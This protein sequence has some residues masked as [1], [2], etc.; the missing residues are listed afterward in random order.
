[1]LVIDCYFRHNKERGEFSLSKHIYMEAGHTT[2]SHP[3]PVVPQVPLY[4][5]VKDFCESRKCGERVDGQVGQ[6]PLKENYELTQCAA[7]AS[8]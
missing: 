1:M 6:H 5:E 3:S 8:F 4:E 7:Y 2:S